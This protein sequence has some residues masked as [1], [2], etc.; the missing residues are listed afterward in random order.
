M[1]SKRSQCGYS[2]SQSLQPDQTLEVYAVDGRSF[3]KG[4][5]LCLE[6]SYVEFGAFA[7]EMVGR[8]E[9]A[10]AEHG[11]PFYHMVL[12]GLSW[13]NRALVSDLDFPL[14]VP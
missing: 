7:S 6:A 9:A 2:L 4:L 5:R 10:S 1:G 8:F 11:C 13:H 14:F 12:C 3:L